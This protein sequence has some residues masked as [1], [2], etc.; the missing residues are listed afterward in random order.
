M[1]L[2]SVE[3]AFVLKVGLEVHAIITSG[4][5]A[6]TLSETALIMV[7]VAP[8]TRVGIGHANAT[9]GSVVPDAI[10]FVRLVSVAAVDMEFVRPVNVVVR[11][12]ILVSIVRRLLK[13]PDVPNSVQVE[14][15]AC[16][17]L[18]NVKKVGLATLVTQ[19]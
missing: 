2:A 18:A 12:G 1:E 7:D 15:F 14:E 10:P 11:M 9:S 6:R 4:T 3:L 17:V 16:K 8:G 13:C 19:R 5:T